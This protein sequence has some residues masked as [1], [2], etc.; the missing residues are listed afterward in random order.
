MHWCAP[1]NSFYVWTT[2]LSKCFRTRPVIRGNNSPNTRLKRREGRS[3]SLRHCETVIKV[4]YFCY[5]AQCVRKMSRVWSGFTTELYIGRNNKPHA[6]THTYKPNVTV[7][8]SSQMIFLMAST[9]KLK[10]VCSWSNSFET[11]WVR[12]YR[13]WSLLKIVIVR[14]KGLQLTL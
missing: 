5:C 9:L 2:F 1:V 8:F 14:K 13:R 4:A 6:H 12:F 7:S 10:K 3:A 11:T